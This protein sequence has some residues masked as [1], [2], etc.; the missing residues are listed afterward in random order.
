MF[1][2]TLKMYTEMTSGFGN[3]WWPSPCCYGFLPNVGKPS[4]WFIV[5]KLS[6]FP[7]FFVHC[8]SWPG[9]WKKKNT[10]SILITWTAV[11]RKKIE[12]RTNPHYFI[13]LA[14]YNNSN[15][16][17]FISSAESK[18]GKRTFVG[19]QS[20]PNAFP[21]RCPWKRKKKKIW[22][23]LQKREL[24]CWAELHNFYLVLLSIS[25]GFHGTNKKGKNICSLNSMIQ[26]KYSTHQQNVVWQFQDISN[27]NIRKP[28][29]R[30]IKLS[31]NCRAWKKEPKKK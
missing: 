16:N 4:T 26:K 21:D 3:I 28:P 7:N 29:P 17:H 5:H 18:S 14:G 12:K 25:D 19:G 11:S 10:T 31:S 13:S 8:F 1:L 2:S 22:C 20:W 23:Q 15:K 30:T 9:Y 6:N 24:V 27:K